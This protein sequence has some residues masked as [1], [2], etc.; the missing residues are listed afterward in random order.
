MKKKY[1]VKLIIIILVFFTS[2]TNAQTN[3]AISLPGGSDGNVSNVALPGLNLTS[4][5]VTIEAWVYP[6][7]KN[8]YGGLF[9]YRGTNTNGGIQF[10]RWTNPNSFRGIANDG[11]NAVAANNIN[12]NDWNHVAWV[13]TSTGMILYVNGIPTTSEEVPAMLPFDSGLYIGWDAATNDRTIQGYFDEVRVWTTERTAQE[14]V[15]NKNKKLTGSETGLYGYWNFDD[16]A[17]VATD[18]TSNHLDGII[19]GGT[20]VVST[21][22]NP[23]TYSSSVVKEKEAF[24]KNN[25]TNNVVFS[26]EIETQNASEPFSLK[27]LALSA[28]GTTSLSDL[29]N[30]K[31]YY[32]G[33]DAKFST[34]QLCGELNQSPLT[35]SF[36]VNCNQTLSQGKN[37]FWI[38]ADVSNSATEGNSIDITCNNFTLESTNTQV[39]TPTSTASTGKLEIKSSIFSNSVKLPASVVTTNAA[40]TFEGSNFASFQQNAIIT[41]NNYQ[42]VTF[43][44]KVSRVCI[45]RRKLPEGDWKTV[46]LT[47]YT[48]SPNRVAD[49]HYT[50]SMGICENDGTIHLAF[51]HH[52]DVLHYRKSIANLA[53]S[54]DTS[55]KMSSFGSVQ[56]NLVDNVNLSN[57]TYPRFVSKPNGDMIYECRIGWSGDGDSFLWEYNGSN[58]K[59]TYIGEYLNGTSVNE[60]AYINGIHYDSNGRLHV[61]WI[62]RGT[63]DAQTN[64]D[65]YYAYSD[66][67]GRTWYNSDGVKV[68]TAGSDPMV[69]SRPGLKIWDIGTNRGLI[70]QESQA[71]DSNGGIHILQSYIMESDSNSNNFWDFRI[72]K[73]YLRH[74]YKDQSGSWRSDVIARSQRNRAEIAVDGN[75][76]LYVVASD[77]RVYFASAE[78]NWQNWTEMDVNEVGTVI[79]EPLIDREA[80]LENDILSFVFTHADKDGKIIVPYYLLERSKKPNGNG[81]QKVVYNNL[82]HPVVEELDAID[83]YNM[84]YSAYGDN[85]NIKWTGQ[86]EIQQPEEYTLHLTS[87]GNVQVYINDELK[88]DT[89]DLSVEQEFTTTLNLYPSYKY[90]IRVEG[91]YSSSNN[92]TTKLEWSSLNVPK[93]MIPLKGYFG[94]LKNLSLGISDVALFPKSL[95]VSPNPSNSFFLVEMDGDF[96]YDI[97]GFDGKK[98][99]SGAAKTSCEV[100]QNL[101]AGVYILK[102]NNGINSYVI[103]IIKY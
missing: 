68:G 34:T 6:I 95:K 9:Y 51:D 1:F 93:D 16:Q 46:E 22:F 4:Y 103:K 31:I 78:N 77:Y 47:D 14:I 36:S 85:I 21:V 24:I 3:Y 70:N 96:T 73:G 62:W 98:I 94:E 86:L 75:N 26:L 72:N 54:D 76:N 40:S 38:T 12:F 81:L 88:I 10:D 28:L 82:D 66:D 53:Y 64:H 63:P 29:N 90:D 35:E 50:I 48:I 61:S 7:A 49:N 89:G 18:Q 30:V 19:N 56:Q 60:N 91:S 100:G 83:L 42:Y 58:G 97:Y 102:L 32:T 44:N 52:N 5:P 55:W 101:L 69:Q 59:W 74:I 65:V 87:N 20:Y 8:N 37:V 2:I 79:N 41:F 27:N 84:D 11:V 33:V 45:A 71:V 67:D 13:V 25:S 17:N 92:V 15:D 99:E 57:I 43:W 80:L 39:L 23:M